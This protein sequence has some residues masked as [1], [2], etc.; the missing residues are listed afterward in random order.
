M[1]MKVRT[2]PSPASIC[3]G[4][5]DVPDLIVQT[6]RRGNWSDVQPTRVRFRVPLALGAAGRGILGAVGLHR[7]FAVGLWLAATVASTAMVWAAT[8]IVAADVTDRPA[9][10][11][12]HDDVVSE[13]E[14]GSSVIG[15]TTTSTTQAVGGP[16]STVPASGQAAAPAGPPVPLPGTAPQAQADVSV[17]PTT[18]ITTTPTTPAA[19]VGVV[20]APGPVGPPASQAGLRPSATYSTDGGV[21]RVECTGVFIDLVSAIPG[22]GYS[23]NVVADGP[24]NVDVRFVGSGQELSV[25]AVCSGEPIR[26]YGQIPPRRAPGPP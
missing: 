12:A 20:P 10:V 11:V 1:S 14:A 22:N 15:I 26:Y 21:V 6:F 3:S 24:E 8:S 23:V 2:P 7:L 5:E 25:K 9:P 13:L 19:G 18:P 16:A 17:A 4:M